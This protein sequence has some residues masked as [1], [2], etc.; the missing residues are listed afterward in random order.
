MF[1]TSTWYSADI[2]LLKLLVTFWGLCST[3]TLITYDKS[4]RQ[5]RLA[6]TCDHKLMFHGVHNTYKPKVPSML[7][8]VMSQMISSPYVSPLL[9]LIKSASFGLVRTSLTISSY[10]KRFPAQDGQKFSK[11]V[12]FS[13]KPFSVDILVVFHNQYWF[14]F[15][16]FFWIQFFFSFFYFFL[17]IIANLI[18]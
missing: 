14:L 16:F 17:K 1:V 15:F 13:S 11:L 2:S 6:K 9:S 10:C 12:N 4:P 5:I 18:Q 8:A 7:G 3:Q